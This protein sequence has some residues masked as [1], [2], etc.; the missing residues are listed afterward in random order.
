MSDISKF[1][2]DHRLV[3]ILQV[4]GSSGNQGGLSSRLDSLEREEESQR[5]SL[6]QRLQAIERRLTTQEQGQGGGTSGLTIAQANR[7]V[8]LLVL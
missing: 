2:G 5:T 4:G 7:R 8:R 1:P 6:E 3:D